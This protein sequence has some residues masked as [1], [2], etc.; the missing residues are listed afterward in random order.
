MGRENDTAFLE[1]TRDISDELLQEKFD[2]QDVLEEDVLRLVKDAPD[3]MGRV[4]GTFFWCNR[5]LYAPAGLENERPE[6]SSD[7]HRIMDILHVPEVDP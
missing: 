3:V 2:N 6:I 5:L 7:M 1:K 4:P